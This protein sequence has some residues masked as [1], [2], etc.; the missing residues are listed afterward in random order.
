MNVMNKAPIRDIFVPAIRQDK[1]NRLPMLL[2]V[3]TTIILTPLGGN[4]TG[5]CK[6]Y[7]NILK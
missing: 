2:P 4:N 7:E 5:F 6:K 1:V 3:N